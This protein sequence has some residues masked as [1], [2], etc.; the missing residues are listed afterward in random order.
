[1][2]RSLRYRPTA[3]LGSHFLWGK[4]SKKTPNQC[5]LN[6]WIIGEVLESPDSFW[7]WSVTSFFVVAAEH[8]IHPTLLLKVPSGSHDGTTSQM[9]HE[10]CIARTNR[11]HKSFSSS[12]GQQKSTNQHLKDHGNLLED[13]GNWIVSILLVC[14]NPPR[15]HCN[16]TGRG[17]R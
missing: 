12:F 15:L 1:V 4:I 17:L 7:A 5:D 2:S 8:I 3:R 16:G 13:H 9:E 10:K 6:E 11:N 14:M